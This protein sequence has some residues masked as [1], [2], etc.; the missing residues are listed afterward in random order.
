MT[1]KTIL[2]LML[3]L[4]CAICISC[5]SRKNYYPGSDRDVIHIFGDGK[6]QIGKSDHDKILIVYHTPYLES[7]SYEVILADVKTYKTKGQASYVV[8][9]E[10]YAV[11]DEKTSLCRV[12]VSVEQQK[13]NGYY[14]TDWSGKTEYIQ[15]RATDVYVTY[16]RN[17][18]EF[19]EDEQLIFKSM[20]E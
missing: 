4:I 17:F 7:E 11:I 15:R 2:I 14:A 1:R 5:S 20:K 16:L 18:E 3:L 10:G 13:Y 6:Y 8:T 12:F 19:T 9:G